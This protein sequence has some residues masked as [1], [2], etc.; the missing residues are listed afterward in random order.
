MHICDS[1]RR[2]QHPKL[3]EEANIACSATIENFHSL[4]NDTLCHGR[5]GNLELLLQMAQLRDD[6]ALRLEVQAQS[7]N[8][9]RDLEEVLSV[10]L[11]SSNSEVS[12]GLM[13]GLAGIGM[14]FLRLA[15]PELVPSP[16]L[17]D[18]PPGERSLP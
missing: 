12:P 4:G 11:N 3:L 7:Y 18:P 15:H 13:I 6:H 2:V 16:L 14:F 9:M 8:I 5:A 10:P 17:L 1:W